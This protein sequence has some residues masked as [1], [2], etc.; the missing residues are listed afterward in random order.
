M[1]EPS[2]YWDTGV[3][4]AGEASAPSPEVLGPKDLLNKQVV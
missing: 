1:K 2:R 4:L 3:V